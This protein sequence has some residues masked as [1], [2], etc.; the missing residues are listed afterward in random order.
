EFVYGEVALDGVPFADNSFDYVFSEDFLEHVP[1]EKAVFVINEIW[2][3]LKPGGIMEHF[4][5]N[6]GSCNDFGS[7]TH[8][9]HWN[10]QC[11]DHF[12]VGS[13]RYKQ[14]KDFEGIKGGFEKIHA[15]R[16]SFIEEED[17][18]TR[19]QSIHVK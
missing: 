19:S 15:E 18:V 16:I 17:G 3:V 2:R 11:F 13:Y 4:V 9:T 8:L 12:D 6:A 10:L 14:D 7:P 5:P 1:P